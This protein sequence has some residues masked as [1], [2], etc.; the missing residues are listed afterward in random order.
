MTPKR[1]RQ[2]L[3]AYGAQPRRWPEPEREAALALLTDSGEARRLLD[4]AR[5][6]D[7]LLDTVPAREATLDAASLAAR[8]TGH[9]QERLSGSAAAARS[10]F[11]FMLPNLIGL[12]AVAAIGFVVGWTDLGVTSDAAVA[13]DATVADLVPYVG[14]LGAEDALPW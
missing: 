9:A 5:A 14:D 13:G 3:A 4:E 2:I 12:A 8:L 7:R 11:R 1:L 6:V 10:R